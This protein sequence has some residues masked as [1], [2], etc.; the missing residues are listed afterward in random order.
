MKEFNEN[1]FQIGQNLYIEASAGTGK[2]HTIEL[3]VAKML[4]HGIPL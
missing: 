1:D 3:L 4:K 2:T